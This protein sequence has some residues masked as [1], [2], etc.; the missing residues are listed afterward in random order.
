MCHG[1]SNF[2]VLLH[3]FVLPKICHQ[4]HKGY[5]IEWDRH[6]CKMTLKRITFNRYMCL[7]ADAMRLVAA[8]SENL[9]L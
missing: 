6:M 1:F 2:I 3:H 5:Q 4:D 8:E 7:H 9:F